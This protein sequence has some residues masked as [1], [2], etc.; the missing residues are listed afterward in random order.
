MALKYAQDVDKGSPEEIWNAVQGT[1][2]EIPYRIFF[3]A[4]P[5]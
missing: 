2:L 1:D 5:I 3:S 4:H